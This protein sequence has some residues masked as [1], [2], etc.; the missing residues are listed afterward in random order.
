MK[1]LVALDESR[2]GETVLAAVASRVWPE[3]SKIKLVTVVHGLETLAGFLDATLA[4]HIFHE[5]S[6]KIQAARRYLT[7][8]SMDLAA[9]L[10]SVTVE[11]EVIVG[12]VREAIL[13]HA[14]EW[15]A[16]LIVVGS[17]GKRGLA[18]M[19]SVSQS[20][21][22]H[23]HCPVLVAKRPADREAFCCDEINV[24]VAVDNSSYS[25][26]TMQWA[27]SQ[28]WAKPVHYCLMTVL[29]PMSD[30]YAREPDPEAA[31]RRLVEFEYVH[32]SVLLSLN[33][34]AS[35][36][37]ATHKACTVDCQVLEGDPREL[38]LELA[39]AW[40]ADLIVMGSH[41]RSG[42]R[43]YLLG[44]VSQSVCLHAQCSTEIV[45][46]E[47]IAE[48]LQHADELDKPRR[49]DDRDYVPHLGGFM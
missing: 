12:H 21:V 11:W 35:M 30:S 29:P 28:S 4:Q 17:H 33:E 2:F 13:E 43:R 37:A 31:Q 42:L 23:A 45:R 18:V 39:A 38:I 32:A 41:G 1:V 16:E 47:D 25:V 34:W 44:S 10:Q 19:G 49:R 5:D 8:A 46:H 26:A 36:L 15:K 40:P 3:G 9:R 14:Q 20:V 48:H 24:L 6:P 22:Q 7:A 27:A